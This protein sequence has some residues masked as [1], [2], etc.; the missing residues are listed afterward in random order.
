MF[1]CKTVPVL[2][3]AVLEVVVVFDDVSQR[4]GLTFE[5]TKNPTIHEI[6]PRASFSRQD[7][8]RIYNRRSIN[9]LLFNRL[10]FIRLKF[11][12]YIAH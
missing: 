3:T 12:F 8:K 2:S 10:Y 1:V 7:M 4:T 6:F 5:Y 9:I 11:A